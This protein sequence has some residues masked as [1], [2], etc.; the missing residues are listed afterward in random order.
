MMRLAPARL[1]AVG[2]LLTLAAGC[3]PTAGDG[4]SRSP[5][6]CKLILAGVVDEA[7]ALAWAGQVEGAALDLLLRNPVLESGGPKAL[8]PDYQGL[9]KEPAAWRGCTGVFA[10]KLVDIEVYT[11]GGDCARLGRTARGLIL[12]EGG[13][14]V[15]FRARAER[16]P[17]KEAVGA[18]V[19]IPVAFPEKGKPVAVRG[20]FLK[21]W[22]ALD[23]G[24]RD[25]MVMPLVA[26]HTVTEI[27]GEGAG[28]LA[29]TR[30]L[31]G[32]L[33]L[34]PIPA[35]E[36]W[37]RPVVELGAR[38]DLR[39]DGKPT[40]WKGLSEALYPLAARDRNPLGDSALA[41]VAIADRAAPK[42]LIEKLR[43]FPREHM[44]ARCVFR[45][46]TAK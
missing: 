36:V 35:P 8:L 25:Y 39:L 31:P 24:G 37:R 38:G 9:N 20:A 7:D 16:P 46:R 17:T 45:F 44:G 41:V 18:D 1:A 6:E 30:M 33:P 5:D 27:T 22:V 29:R 3:T 26:A 4:K 15:A 11:P 12:L 32:K 14:L 13:Q 21:R 43:K 23:A 28:K 34:K 10:G 40:T 42:E 2:L 19:M